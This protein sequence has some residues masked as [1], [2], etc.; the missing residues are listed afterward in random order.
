MSLWI[1][2][3]SLT[4]NHSPATPTLKIQ[5]HHLLA[6]EACSQYAL[7]SSRLPRAIACRWGGGNFLELARK[8]WDAGSSTFPVMIWRRSEP[9]KLHMEDPFPQF[10][11]GDLRIPPEV[12]SYV[13][14]FSWWMNNPSSSS[15]IHSLNT[16]KEDTQSR[17]LGFTSCTVPQILK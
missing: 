1:P 9:G 5:G 14:Y 13:A 17:Y 2:T 4:G 16:P 15:M 10:S 8:Y 3:R 12:R 6:H 7:S 11:K